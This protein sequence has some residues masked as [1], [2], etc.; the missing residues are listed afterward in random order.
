MKLVCRGKPDSAALFTLRL[1]FSIIQPV[2]HRVQKGCN[3]VS[4]VAFW[5][6]TSKRISGRINATFNFFFL[7][8]RF[9]SVKNGIVASRTWFWWACNV[10]QRIHS[11]E[12]F[13]KLFFENACIRTSWVDDHQTPLCSTICFLW[14]GLLLYCA[15]ALQL[16]DVWEVTWCTCSSSG[17][18][19][20]DK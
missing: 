19:L 1:N 20:S 16:L 5:I 6:P 18:S 7:F 17:L 8:I 12:C 9:W 11:S 2:S 13:L 10:G 3:L 14:Y 15:S 4:V